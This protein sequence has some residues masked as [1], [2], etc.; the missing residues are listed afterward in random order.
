MHILVRGVAAVVVVTS[1]VC[2]EAVDVAVSIAVVHQ[3]SVAG[4]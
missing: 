4:V 1:V 2:G 3:R